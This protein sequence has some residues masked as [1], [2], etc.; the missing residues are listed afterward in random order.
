MGLVE[1]DGIPAA[2][3]EALGEGFVLDEIE[4]ADRLF[5]EAPRVRAAASPGLRAA[6][7]PPVENLEAFVELVLH[8]VLPLEQKRCGRDD[9]DPRVAVPVYELLDDQPRLDRLPQPDLVGDDEPLVETAH[10]AVRALH[11]VR[12]DA[13]P[14]IGER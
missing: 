11:L 14:R 13:R 5:A 2:G 1:Y 3:G 12:E 10:D 7:E 4:R 9:E 6:D 8:F